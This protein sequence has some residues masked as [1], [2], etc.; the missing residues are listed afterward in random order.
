MS[1]IKLRHVHTDGTT[2]SAIESIETLIDCPNAWMDAN[3]I[4]E[5]CEFEGTEKEADALLARL[6]TECESRCNESW[7]ANQQI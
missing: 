5:C 2:G 7:Q 4:K 6:E 1:D 3:Q